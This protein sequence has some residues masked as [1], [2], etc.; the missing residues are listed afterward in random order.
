MME[1]LTQAKA[2]WYFTSKQVIATVDENVDC[3]QLYFKL[4][5]SSGDFILLNDGIIEFH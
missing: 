2:Q 4:D 5:T 3:C 1:Y